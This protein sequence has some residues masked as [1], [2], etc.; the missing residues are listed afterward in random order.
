MCGEHN[1]QDERSK[2]NVTWV[3]SSFGPVRSLA[4]SKFDKITSYVA[5]MWCTI[6]RMKGHRFRSQ[7]CLLC[8]FLLI[9]P[10]HII[11]GIQTTHEGAMCLA[12]FSV[13]KGQRS[14]WH[15]V[16][17]VLT[18]SAPWLP[19]YLTQSLHIWHTY[20]TWG[21]DV[22]STIFRTTGQMSMPQGS[23]KVFIM[24]A[25]WLPPDFRLSVL[26]LHAYLTGPWQL[27]GT[28]AM[29]SLDLLVIFSI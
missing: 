20:N 14:R 17:Q 10:N 4:S 13:W 28:A 16:F 1:Y 7:G 3:V 5:Y 26:W 11:C 9:W 2:V 29:R 24:S 27:R 15:G 21:G 18:L 25:S 19:P 23:F 22:L 6:F 12:L 8:G